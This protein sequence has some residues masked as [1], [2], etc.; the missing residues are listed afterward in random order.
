[1]VFAGNDGLI[2]TVHMF[3]RGEVLSPKLLQVGPTGGLVQG[4]AAEASHAPAPEVARTFADMERELYAQALARSKGNISAAAR[5]L[6]LS[7]PAFEYRLRKH[8]GA[9]AL[10]ATS[11]TQPTGRRPGPRQ[12][13]TGRQ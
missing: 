10:L 11:G 7:R 2:D 6:G 3:H 9:G 5:E 1:V 8:G 12:P 13:P 4:A